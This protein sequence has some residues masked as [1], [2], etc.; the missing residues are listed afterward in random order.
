MD[1]CSPGAPVV[2]LNRGSYTAD[3]TNPV[4]Y[5]NVLGF[6]SFS[7]GQWG[8]YVDITAGQLDSCKTGPFTYMMW[9]KFTKTTG[10]NNMGSVAIAFGHDAGG[11]SGFFITIILRKTVC[12]TT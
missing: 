4:G 11:D 3:A 10:I 1:S 2:T 7:S 9:V 8:A 6:D 5:T 12:W